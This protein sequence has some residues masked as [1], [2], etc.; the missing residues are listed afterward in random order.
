MDIRKPEVV[1]PVLKSVEPPHK[2]V[3]VK[4]DDAPHPKYTTPLGTKRVHN[5]CPARV[6]M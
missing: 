1:A 6:R 3:V 5:W 2:G 4:R